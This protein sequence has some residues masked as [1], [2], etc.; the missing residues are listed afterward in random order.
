M[1]NKSFQLYRR[2]FSC[3]SGFWSHCQIL[4]YDPDIME[5][6][7]KLFPIKAFALLMP[8]FLTRFSSL[9]MYFST[10]CC[11]I[12]NILEPL[13]FMR[14][15]SSNITSLGAL[16]LVP[17]SSSAASASSSCWSGQDQC[18]WEGKRSIQSES[19]QCPFKVKHF[20]DSKISFF[21]FVLFFW[22]TGLI[23]YIE[24]LYSFSLIIFLLNFNI[25]Y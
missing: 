17:K 22:K 23:Y 19:T 15:S 13:F 16:I 20:L 11:L 6:H 12:L 2:P 7:Y 18:C 10:L 9:M 14:D 25:S 5:S 3:M 21:F 4:F 24:A 8:L 1:Q